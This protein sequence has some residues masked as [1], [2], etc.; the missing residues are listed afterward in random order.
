[1]NYYI[2]KKI[3]AM[4]VGLDEN[5]PEVDRLFSDY[6]ERI[7]KLETQ[8]ITQYMLNNGIDPSTV[9]EF[10]LDYGSSDFDPIE[11]DTKYELLSKTL[12]MQE[13]NEFIQQKVDAY[14]KIVYLKFS[15]SLTADQINAIN[16]YIKQ[17]EVE[18]NKQIEE[19]S[20]FLDEVITEVE[21]RIKKD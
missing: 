9:F 3:L 12:N 19:Y 8:S 4:L 6:N 14:N 18:L 2:D 11:I 17:R 15:K 10:I 1:M 16:S 7:R 13:M 20:K 21:T 5:L